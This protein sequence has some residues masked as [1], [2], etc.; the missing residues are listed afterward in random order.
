[1]RRKKGQNY[2]GIGKT[3]SILRKIKSEGVTESLLAP[4]VD[5]ALFKLFEKF[6]AEINP[7]GKVAGVIQFISKYPSQIIAYSETSIRLFDV[8]LKHKN[9]TVSWDATGSIIKETSSRRLL[10]YELSITLLGIVNEDSI[11]PIT[12]MISDAHA[13]VNIIHWLQLFKHSYSQ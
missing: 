4:D 7:E 5:Q 8:P 9:V 10:Y 6:Q 12:F 3:R 13:L 2:D 1:M 11:V